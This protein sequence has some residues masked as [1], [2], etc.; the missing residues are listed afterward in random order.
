MWL[1]VNKYIAQYDVRSPHTTRL[2][3]YAHDFFLL[4][5]SVPFYQVVRICRQAAAKLRMQGYQTLFST[6]PHKVVRYYVTPS[7]TICPSVHPSGCP[8]ISTSFPDPNFSNFLPI[9]FKLCMDTDIWEEWFG[10]ANWLNLFINNR[11]MALD[12]CK[13]VFFLN[14]LRKMDYFW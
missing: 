2:P 10:I 8:S 5:V 13:N 4:C 12:W 11:V 7:K 9:F 6:P 3:C 14:I 1:Y